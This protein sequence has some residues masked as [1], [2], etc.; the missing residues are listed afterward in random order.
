MSFYPLD[1]DRFVK[2]HL[3]IF[4]SIPDEGITMQL[5]GDICSGL[6]YLHGKFICHRDLKPANI[7]VNFDKAVI[8][9]LDSL[10]IHLDSLYYILEHF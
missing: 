9:D 3:K 7:L 1:L 10:S 8:G 5:F 2:D 6:A 4:E